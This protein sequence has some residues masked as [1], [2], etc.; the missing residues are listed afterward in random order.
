MKLRERL[1]K[2][3]FQ[4]VDGHLRQLVCCQKLF[5]PGHKLHYQ[6]PT[7]LALTPAHLPAPQLDS[8][9]FSWLP[10]SPHASGRVVMS[11]SQPPEP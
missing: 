6:A 5:L 2:L 8:W 9:C 1:L 3:G 4:V 11:N 10:A 7:A